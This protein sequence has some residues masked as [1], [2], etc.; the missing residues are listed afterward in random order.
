MKNKTIWVFLVFTLIFIECKKKSIPQLAELP[1]LSVVNISQESD[2][3]YWVVGKKDYYYLKTENSLPKS[4]LFHSSE[5]NKDYS[6]FFTDNG[7]I[8]KVAVDGYIFIFRN[9][10]GYKVD[11]GIIDPN[12]NIQITREI[13]TDFNWDNLT[14]KS[15]NLTL[16][17]S[18]LTVDWSDVIRL[19]GRVVGGVPCA[20][21]IIA[22]GST[23]GVLTPLALWSCGNYVLKLSG[24]LLIHE[25]DIHNGFTEFVSDY[26]TVSL[27]ANCTSPDPTSCLFSGAARGF[28][29]WADYQEQMEGLRSGDVQTTVAALDYGYGDV[30]ATL[31]WDNDADLD[32]HV[33]DPSGE[34]IWWHNKYAYSGGILDVDDINGYGPENIYWPQGEAPHGNYEVYIHY[35]KWPNESWRPSTSNYTV[36]LTAFGRI[37][38]FSGSIALDETIHIQNFDQNGLKSATLVKSF[39]ISKLKK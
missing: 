9:F 19:T 8:D 13:E 6:I 33:I 3:D 28:S 35:Y 24:D 37:K 1:D 25:G 14:L 26:N 4:V 15:G 30:Q 38:K 29:E 34:E 11:I 16:K 32:L 39:T 36:L 31:I 5:A 21:S 10:N 17:S 12:G 20:L 2:W 23:S 27:I 18:N 22:A 7:R